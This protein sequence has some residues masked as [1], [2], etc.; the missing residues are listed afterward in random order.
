M[1]LVTFFMESLKEYDRICETKKEALK[2]AHEWAVENGSTNI[3]EYPDMVVTKDAKGN[4][5][6]YVTIKEFN[7]REEEDAFDGLLPGDR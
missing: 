5:L 6:T 2:I 3:S 7:N 4:W 1:L